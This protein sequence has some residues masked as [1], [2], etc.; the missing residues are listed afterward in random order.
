MALKKNVAMGSMALVLA[1]SGI[2]FI[3]LPADTDQSPSNNTSVIDEIEII[4]T[5]DP[6]E[7]VDSG[8]ATYNGS[9]NISGLTT[10]PNDQVVMNKRNFVDGHISSIN[11]DSVSLT[12][13]KGGDVLKI[14]KFGTRI[15]TTQKSSISP[16]TKY[17]EGQITYVVEQL[18]DQTKYSVEDSPIERSVVH[19][20]NL[21]LTALNSQEMR[22]FREIDGGYQIEFVGSENL[23]ELSATLD[24][25]KLNSVQTTLNVTN[26]GVI[27]NMDIR[28]AGSDNL[29]FPT[30][31]TYSYDIK[32]IGQVSVQE[33]LWV[34]EAKDS[35]SLIETSVNKQN[36]W[37]IVEHKGLREIDRGAKVNIVPGNDIPFNT[38]IDEEI[39]EGDKLY[40]YPLSVSAW[41]YEVNQEP[42][43]DGAIDVG[44]TEFIVEISK[45]MDGEEIKYYEDTIIT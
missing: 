45:E 35:V 21:I 4:D 34:S 32:K 33:P 40:L 20:G 14:Q 15:S 30:T 43:R 23:S 37:I 10:L 31:T 6:T 38:T 42:S 24:E 2:L 12:Y 28:V 3:F 22:E 5:P 18:G 27:R 7:D 29:G 8:S 25:S 44:S 13:N 36:N 19:K 17:T 26:S 9:I 11:D 16:T 41:D 39:S 1:I